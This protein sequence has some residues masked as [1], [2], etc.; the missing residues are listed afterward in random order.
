[1]NMDRKT[2][3]KVLFVGVTLI[4]IYLGLQHMDIVLQF[5]GWLLYVTMPFIV[6]ICCSFFLN[7]PLKM[8]E[9]HLFR[10]RGE[11][12]V[13]PI[14][15][16]LRRPVALALSIMIFLAVIV[17]FLIIII[18][19]IGNS[20]NS[21]SQAIVPAA[22]NVNDM[23]KGWADENE[24]VFQIV[25]FFNPD[26]GTTSVVDG[27]EVTNTIV[28]NSDAIKNVLTDF[29][30]SNAGGL[31]NYTVDM[32][33]SIFNAAVNIFLGI[34]LS[35]YVLLKKEKIASDVKK[36][37]FA[38]FPRRTADFVV[39]VGHLTNKSFYNTMT[40]QIMECIIL[41]SLTALGMTILG[42]P[43]AALVGVM[44]AI[45]S[46]IPMFGVYIGAGIGALFLMTSDFM[47]AVWFIV[48]MI[49]L[50]QVEGNLIYPRVVG[51][52]VGLPPIIVISAIILFSNFFGVLGL[53]VCVPITSVLYT[54]I[55]RLVFTKLR[56]KKIPHYKYEVRKSDNLARPRVHKT[57]HILGKRLKFT[58]PMKLIIK[59]K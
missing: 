44:V 49:C 37:I 19:E 50:Q 27:K 30:S 12:P 29:L 59:K 34:I 41:G 25:K 53:L 48:F 52:N 35:I 32:L 40:G 58:N 14:L 17:A 4:V 42:F 1:M 54:L 13:N 16:K 22:N 51:N 3:Q 43:Y 11:K 56:A 38:L 33:R 6:A 55:R 18:P 23:V 20:L 24:N 15:E 36:F 21:L 45:L 39:E 9:K 47:Q 10:Q 31:V 5:L 26:Y 46:W 28:I 8:I 2:I 57:K 7:V